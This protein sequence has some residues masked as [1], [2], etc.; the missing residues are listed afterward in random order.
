MSRKVI[1]VERT[2]VEMSLMSSKNQSLSLMEKEIQLKIER[3]T[4]QLTILS[5]KKS[6]LSKRYNELKAQLGNLPQ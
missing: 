5:R 6:S 1:N 3:L 2:K 4:F